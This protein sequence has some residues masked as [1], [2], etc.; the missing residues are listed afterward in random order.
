MKH[1]LSKLSKNDKKVYFGVSGERKPDFFSKT[2]EVFLN[3]KYSH[4]ISIY[5]SHDLED[6][7]ITNAHGESVQLDLVDDFYQK[8][9]VVRLWECDVNDKQR[10]IYIRRVVALDG[11]KYGDRQIF[12][13]FFK[14]MFGI[15]FKFFRNKD[16]AMICSEYVDQLSIAVGLPNA[17]DIFDKNRDLL[18][19][20][21]NVK[22][23][24]QFSEKYDRIREIKLNE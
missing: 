13:I 17:S 21:D 19:P 3:R 23:W 18:T 4:S 22:A 1:F 7:I 8:K 24:E 11:V 12:R 6:F 20:K 9:Q 10:K 14:K 15:V 2:T 5:W 16:K